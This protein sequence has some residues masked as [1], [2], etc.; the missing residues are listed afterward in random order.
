MKT[1][2]YFRK[3]DDEMCYTL[4]YHIMEA[5]DEGLEEIE[6]FEAVPDKLDGFFWCKAVSETTEDG[7]CGKQCD[8]YEPKNGKSGM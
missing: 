3:E 4:E 1:K 5:K 6:L 7:F 8:D 2:F